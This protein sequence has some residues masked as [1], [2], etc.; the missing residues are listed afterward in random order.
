MT[1]SPL[2]FAILDLALRQFRLPRPPFSRFS[3]VAPSGAVV[4]DLKK[5][6]CQSRKPR[7]L[8][9]LLN[10]LLKQFARKKSQS[11]S[12]S[13]QSESTNGFTETFLQSRKNS[14]TKCGEPKSSAASKKEKKRN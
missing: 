13:M 9:L 5:K 6:S 3:V 11:S 12:S 14:L 8:S 7:S 1:C 4:I 2:Y 10:K